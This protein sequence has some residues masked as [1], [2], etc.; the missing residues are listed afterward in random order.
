MAIAILIVVVLVAGIFI[1]FMI[2]FSRAMREAASRVQAPIYPVIGKIMIILGFVVLFIAVAATLHTWHFTR[3]AKR[4]TGT[5]VEMLQQTDKDSGSVSYAPTFRFQ[6]ATGTQHTVTS[7]LYSS[8][9]EF[10]VGDNVAVLYRSDDP[11]TARIDSRMQVWGLPIVLVILGSIELPIG[12][13]FLFWPKIKTRFTG[14]TDLAP[15]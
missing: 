11:Q 5:V 13:V 14:R 6:D 10:H 8:P 12:F 7:S 9:P 3:I 15:A 1:G 4:A 2:G